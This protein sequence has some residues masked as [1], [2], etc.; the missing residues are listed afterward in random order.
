M[1]QNMIFKQQTQQIPR[2][3][4]YRTRSKTITMDAQLKIA[5]WNSILRIETI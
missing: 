1:E 2:Y 4:I 5:V 3:N